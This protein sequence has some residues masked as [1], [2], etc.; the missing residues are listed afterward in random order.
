M[1]SVK[2]GEK[3][4]NKLL[5]TV[6]IWVLAFQNPLEGVHH[7]FAY[8]DELAGLAGVAC[9]V[10]CLM[11]S[12]KW[13]LSR[14]TL[15]ILGALTLFVL[16]CLW[17]NLWYGY[18]PLKPV[19]IDLF[20]N[21]KF[22][23]AIVA[24]YSLFG[25]M[26]WEDIK[27]C[28][29]RTGRVITAFLFCL[30]FL[31]RILDIWP[32]GLRHGIKSATL[33]FSHPTYLAGAMAFLLV[34]LTVGYEKR[35]L[36]FLAMATLM[37]CFT[38]RSKAIASAGVY[39]LFFVFFVWLHKDLKLGHVVVAGA[40]CA[41]AGWPMLRYYYIDLAGKGT[42]SVLTSLSITIM[43]DH[44]PLGTG[45]GTFAS[46]AAEK[47][48]SSV[49]EWYELAH[50]CRFDVGWKNF[51]CDTFWPIIIAQSGAIGT[52][53]FLWILALLV[54]RCFA[55]KDLSRNAFAGA[56]YV[57]AYLAISSTSEPAFHNSVAIPLALML[58]ILFAKGNRAA[59][60]HWE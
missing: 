45:F 22:F 2:L 5:L 38:M 34:L 51:L 17:G 7:I 41:V 11:Y 47:Y 36:P 54:K 8:V 10:V 57:F 9:C 27:D 1:I 4:V 48:Y 6:V 42:R 19:L 23:L 43:Q 3:R 60:T 13:K 25:G 12:R 58:G 24:G 30:F 39:V 31:D 33:F 35:N 56:L 46:S 16:I 53:V 40:A 28:I 37:M 21:L 15:G 14:N 52:L 59:T 44:F 29:N 49:Y 20:T 55:L 32:A 26:K 18:Q 50:L